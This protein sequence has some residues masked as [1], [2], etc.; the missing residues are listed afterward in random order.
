LA[1]RES[2]NEESKHETWLS[3]PD[4][5]VTCHLLELASM[6]ELH[7]LILDG[8]RFVVPDGFSRL[9]QELRWF[10]W[11]S[12]CFSTLPSHLQLPCLVVLDLSNSYKLTRL[13]ESDAHIQVLYFYTCNGIIL[14][15]RCDSRV[16]K[17]VVEESF[18]VVAIVLLD[19]DCGM[20]SCSFRCSTRW[21]CRFMPGLRSWQRILART[22]EIGNE[23]LCEFEEATGVDWPLD[24]LGAPG[25]RLFWRIEDFAR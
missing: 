23:L 19:L 3:M 6:E 7:L 11:R 22:V 1:I 13:W 17:H 18:R 15:C 4:S 8:C 14:F 9:P 21:F 10:Q 25:A 16:C 2:T 24:G 12:F 20:C 5:A